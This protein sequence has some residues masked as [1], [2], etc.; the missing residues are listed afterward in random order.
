[1]ELGALGQGAASIGAILVLL[2]CGVPVGVAM[3]AVAG[4][5]MYLSVNPN[6]A[7]AMFR[8]LP[9]AVTS[10]YT[11]VVVPMFVLM[12]IIASRAGIIADLYDAAHRFF[13]RMK[14]SL[15][16]STIM[17]SAGFGAASGSTIVAASVFTKIALPE[18]RRYNYH[19]GV[20]AGCIAAAG[21]LA[22]L[23][24]PSIIMVILAVLTDQSIGALLMAGVI[25]GILTA[26]IYILGVRVFVGI[27]PDWAPPI[28]DRFT[29]AERWQS[30]R[31]VWAVVVLAVLV[32]GGI[33][34][35]F[36]APSAAGAVGAAGALAIALV[37]R[38]FSLGALWE[39]LLETARITA[40]LFFIFIGGLM[41]SRALVITGF[42]REVNDL[43]G[44]FG[45]TPAGFIAIVILVYFI[46]GMFV[47]SVS[48]MVITL[49]FI[50]PMSQTLGIDPIWF[51][52]LLIKLVEIAAITPPIG[53]NLYAVLTAAGSEVTARQIFIGVLPFVL[54][55]FVF[56]A[57]LLSVPEIA[58][59]L[60]AQMR[61]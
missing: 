39:S 36:F 10:N 33:Y 38:R 6:F 50:F 23:I 27:R 11:Y 15:Y 53:L 16:I 28:E 46:L 29:W 34:K 55:E 44:V 31:R 61:G 20:S 5:T 17:A 57:L 47:D 43:I 3:I 49:P 2:F 59:W 9:Y 48:V 32:I 42:I 54:L 26:L 18:M 22:A 35:G 45:I 52:V 12:G 30:L 51:S 21:T 19:P 1:M 7:F 24:P 14:G 58:T 60:P 13:S 56:L 4:L 37:M 8:T 41:L 25:P 40:V